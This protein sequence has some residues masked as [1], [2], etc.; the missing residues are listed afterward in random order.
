MVLWLI[1]CRPIRA[2]CG[3]GEPYREVDVVAAEVRVHGVVDVAQGVLD[4]YWRREMWQGREG[5]AAVWESTEGS[6]F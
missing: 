4:V 3:C 1:P 2:G 6:G 5:G